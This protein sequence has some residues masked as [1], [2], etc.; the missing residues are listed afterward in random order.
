MFWRSG[1]MTK[2]FFEATD[3]DFMSLSRLGCNKN[4]FL[5]HRAHAFLVCLLCLFRLCIHGIY[6]GFSFMLSIQAM[7]AKPTIF[8]KKCWGHCQKMRLDALIIFPIEWRHNIVILIRKRSKYCKLSFISAFH[9]GYPF[10]LFIQTVHSSSPFRL[11][12]QAIHSGYA[13]WSFCQTA[14]K[15]R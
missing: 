5:R 15:K 11:C 10:R 6:S 7:P 13:F 3:S 8:L 14:T 12:S 9:A 2:R 4:T 1:T